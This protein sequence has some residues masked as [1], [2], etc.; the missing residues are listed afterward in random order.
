VIGEQVEQDRQ[1]GLVVEL[2][3]DDLERIG[4]EDPEQFVV[5]QAQQLL[6]AGGAAQNS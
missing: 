4:V 1:L 6:K 2:P 5:A 3:A